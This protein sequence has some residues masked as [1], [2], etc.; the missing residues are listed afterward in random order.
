MYIAN[1]DTY[2]SHPVR[3]SLI[4]IKNDARARPHTGDSATCTISIYN[5]PKTVWDEFLVKWNASHG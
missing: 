1:T 2:K 5:C 3:E 4:I